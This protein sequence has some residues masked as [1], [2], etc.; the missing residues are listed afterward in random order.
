MKILSLVLFSFSEPSV[1]FQRTHFVKLG[2]VLLFFG[3]ALTFLFCLRKDGISLIAMVSPGDVKY[4]KISLLAQ[5]HLLGRAR[6]A[7]CPAC[8]GQSP[9]GENYPTQNARV[10]PYAAFLLAFPH[11]AHFQ[12]CNGCT[13]NY[14]NGFHFA[15][16]WACVSPLP[17]MLLIL[18]FCTITYIEG[19][20]WTL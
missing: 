2:A 11:R 18:L 8:T 9:S 14:A 4:V 20:H 13:F 12:L 19:W 7:D 5:W 3:A 16:R 6:D 1:S 10:L 15:T 17:S